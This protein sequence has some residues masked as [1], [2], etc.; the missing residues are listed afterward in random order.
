MFNNQE[1]RENK[2]IV[3]PITASFRIRLDEARET[4]TND[5][6]SVNLI[7]LSTGSAF[8]I[9][10]KDL[11]IGTILDFKIELSEYT[12]T[13]DC[14]GKITRIEQFQSTSMFCTAIRFIDIGE[15]EEEMLKTAI[16]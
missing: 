3:K 11:G 8:F 13:I 7:N 9:Y 5:W 6:F 14:V 10:K 2:R 4:E 16:E 15:Q 1:R 12:P